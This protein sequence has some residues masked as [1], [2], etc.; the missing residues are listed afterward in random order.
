MVNIF[1]K[2]KKRRVKKTLDNLKNAYYEA[3]SK[4]NL[5]QQLLTGLEKDFNAQINKYMSLQNQIQ[6]SVE[7]LIEIALNKKT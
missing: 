1:L 7:R 2:K 5:R 3:E 6:I 4:L